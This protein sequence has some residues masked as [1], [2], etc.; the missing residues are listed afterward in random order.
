VRARVCG[1]PSGEPGAD[2]GRGRGSS[3][4][5]PRPVGRRACLSCPGSGAADVGGND[6]CRGGRRRRPALQTCSHHPRSPSGSKMRC[7]SSRLEST[8]DE[9][10]CSS[11]LLKSAYPHSSQ[12]EW[13]VA[14]LVSF[15]RNAK[16]S[17]CVKAT[18]GVGP[19][20]GVERDLDRGSL[21]RCVGDRVPTAVLAGGK[22]APV[23]API[24]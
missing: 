16:V 14:A 7:S 12:A 17:N 5:K 15:P 3:G 1:L 2:L 4:A 6:E 10:L 19:G 13:A 18:L 20:A 9:G 22:R 8:C 21:R 11:I 24:D 23:R